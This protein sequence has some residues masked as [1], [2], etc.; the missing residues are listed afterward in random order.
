MYVL[1]TDL[2]QNPHCMFT[3][4]CLTIL[5]KSHIVN[6]TTGNWDKLY[7][8]VEAVTKAEVPAPSQCPLQ[9]EF[10]LDVASNNA[11]ILGDCGFNLGDT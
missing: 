11:S 8:A 7:E 3:R 9:F 5:L 1:Y 6:F 2:E 4:P 10:A